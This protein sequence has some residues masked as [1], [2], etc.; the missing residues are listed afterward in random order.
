MNINTLCNEKTG[1][2]NYRAPEVKDTKEG[3]EP[4]KADIFSLGTVG[5]SILFDREPFPE[6][7]INGKP[8]IEPGW[9]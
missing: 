9:E 1:T 2:L 7:W 6:T 8:A 3:Y 5:F 4:E